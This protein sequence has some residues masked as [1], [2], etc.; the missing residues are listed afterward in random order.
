MMG[1]VEPCICGSFHPQNR[2]MWPP[3]ER[4]KDCKTVKLVNEAKQ[5]GAEN[6]HKRVTDLLENELPEYRLVLLLRHMTISGE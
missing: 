6:M 1:T 5:E 2:K 3:S 4:Y